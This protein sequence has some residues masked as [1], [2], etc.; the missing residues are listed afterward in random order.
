MGMV[1]NLYASEMMDHIFIYFMRTY[2]HVT[3]SGI[4]KLPLEQ[5]FA[6]PVHSY[7]KLAIDLIIE[8]ELPET[9][10]LILKSEYDSILKH[11]ECSTELLLCL[12]VIWKTSWHLHYDA[13]PCA[14]LFDLMNLW[15]NSVFAYASAT[16]YPKLSKEMQL[17]HHLTEL[18]E[19]MP[20]HLLRLYDY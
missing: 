15:G 14:Y 3:E 9:S 5:D 1:R 10:E 11:Y 18:V 7:L 12:N 19:R 6:E 4:E 16:F 8:G 17:K 2:L 20:P 13:D